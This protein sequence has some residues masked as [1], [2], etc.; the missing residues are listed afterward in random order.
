M[1]SNLRGYLSLSIVAS[2][3]SAGILSAQQWKNPMAD[4]T[5]NFYVL[6]AQFNHDMRWKTREIDRESRNNAAQQQANKSGSAQ[7]EEESE[8]NMEGYL[9]YKH[10]KLTVNQEIMRRSNKPIKEEARRPKKNRKLI[11]KAISNTNAGKILWLPAFIL[12]AISVLLLPIGPGLR[13]T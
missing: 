13:I 12:P 1:T 5:Q 4:N 8:A 7:G 2:L 6:Q 10:G 9:Q 3:L 11:W